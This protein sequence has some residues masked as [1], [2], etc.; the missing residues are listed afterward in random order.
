LLEPCRET[1]ENVAKLNYQLSI[2][3]LSIIHS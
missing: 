2:I 1:T 3:Q